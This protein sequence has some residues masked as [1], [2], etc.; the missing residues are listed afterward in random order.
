MAVK[1]ENLSF[2]Y[3]NSRRGLEDVNLNIKAGRKTAILG[4]NGSGK[5]TLLYHLNGIS[6]AQ[7]GSVEVLKRY[8]FISRKKSYVYW[9][10]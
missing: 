6:L 7:T 8:Y 10:L 4:V 3:P 1:I 9:A 2:L 5:S